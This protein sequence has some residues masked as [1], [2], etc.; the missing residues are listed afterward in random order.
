VTGGI[1]FGFGG[2]R[3]T[4]DAEVKDD[5][6]SIVPGFYAAGNATS[7]LFYD[8]YPGGTG[9]MNAAVYGKIAAEQAASYV[10]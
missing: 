10:D 1:T 2:V 9:L 7:D 4:P 5:R 6:G 8:N 3:I